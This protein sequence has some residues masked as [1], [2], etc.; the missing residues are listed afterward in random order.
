MAAAAFTRPGM[1]D[2]QAG[3]NVETYLVGTAGFWKLMPGSTLLVG[4]RIFTKWKQFRRERLEAAAG[5]AHPPT[6][7]A[8]YSEDALMEMDSPGSRLDGAL[9]L[10]NPEEQLAT[11]QEGQLFLQL[12]KLQEKK[13]ENKFA[14]MQSM[15]KAQI[16]T[17]QI[18]MDQRDQKKNDEIDLLRDEVRKQKTTIQT[19]NKRL[20]KI[21]EQND[22]EQTRKNSKDID[23]LYEYDKRA[24]QLSWQDGHNKMAKDNYIKDIPMK[25]PNTV[26]VAYNLATPRTTT[27]E[28]MDMWIQQCYKPGDTVA[29]RNIAEWPNYS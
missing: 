20:S 23:D 14:Q 1:L 26:H 10:P 7:L 18:G 17:L 16:Q 12:L 25:S 24:G 11:Q 29:E 8:F 21:T 9:E 4:K 27:E 15:N 6:T 28:F 13:F 22:K 3:G 5:A 19:Q 2:Y